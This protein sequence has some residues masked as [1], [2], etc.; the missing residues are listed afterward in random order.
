MKFILGIYNYIIYQIKKTS[1][2]D[3][4]I[5]VITCL[6]I[7]FLM[8]YSSTLFTNY[9]DFWN[10][11]GVP[12]RPYPFGDL[13]VITSGIE[14]HRL[15]YNIYKE[16]PCNPWPYFAE[17]N[18]PRIWLS[19]T[20]LGLS[21][22]HTILLGTS[23]IIIFLVMVLI[24]IK[25]LNFAEG[26]IYSLVLC[27]PA[28][29]LGI[30]RANNDLIIFIILSISLLL[31]NSS[32]IIWRLTSYLLLLFAAILKIYPIFALSLILRESRR[33]FFIITTFLTG[34]FVSYLIAEFNNFKQVYLATPQ[35]NYWS[36][37]SKIL[38]SSLFNHIKAII[39]TLGINKQSIYRV[40]PDS[41]SQK[42]ILLLA[43]VIFVSCLI[44]ILYKLNYQI[45]ENI[46][47]NFIDAFRL[48]ASI[49]IGSFLIT[50]SWAYRLIFLI[51]TLP[52]ILSWMKKESCL[53]FLSMFSILA[54]IL[55]VWIKI[56]AVAGLLFYVDQI[57][58]WV[59]LFYF[60]YTLI[61]TLPQWFKK[62]LF[63]I[64]NKASQL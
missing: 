32:Q 1:S 29:M 19:L 49:Y 57:M 7:Y 14:C 36:Y 52:Q 23:I 41:F 18:Y 28:V 38:L 55:T 63:I 48:G 40:L 59:I 53:R 22:S 15:G 26:L 11:L 47:I 34:V 45:N 35:V 3:G 54:I 42:I 37:G 16:N 21:S 56:K 27:S 58:N 43:I 46:N 33:K 8:I 60:I 50:N 62:Q 61:L 13:W 25:N 2:F 30:E 24:S 17:F 10:L 9:Y 39:K 4:R 64:D 20:N 12:A 51:F 31:I 6:S 44:Y 5:I